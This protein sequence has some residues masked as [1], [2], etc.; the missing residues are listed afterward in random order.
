MAKRKKRSQKKGNTNSLSTE[1]LCEI[2]HFLKRKKTRKKKT[3]PDLTPQQEWNAAKKR[4]HDI[5][6]SCR[7]LT[8]KARLETN[9]KQNEEYHKLK[10]FYDKVNEHLFTP[11]AKEN[12]ISGKVSQ[13]ERTRYNIYIKCGV[14]PEDMAKYI[15]K[16]RLLESGQRP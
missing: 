16:W 3:Q 8:E 6:E 7:D 1:Q 10:K 4:A 9:A 2:P 15:L 11:E 14:S 12:H 5:A 13:Q